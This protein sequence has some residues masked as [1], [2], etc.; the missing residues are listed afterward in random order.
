MQID[1]KQSQEENNEQ[2]SENNCPNCNRELTIK[3]GKAKC[4]FCLIC[5]DCG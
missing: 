3:N 4:D 2:S 1:I 5:I